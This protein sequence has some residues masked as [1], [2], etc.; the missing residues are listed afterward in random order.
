MRLDGCIENFG[1]LAFEKT[2]L[3]KMLSFGTQIGVQHQLP[4]TAHS[5]TVTFLG[6]GM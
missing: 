1:Y 3:N 4:D 2:K 6:S 5:H